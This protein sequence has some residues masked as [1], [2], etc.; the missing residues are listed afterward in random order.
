[1]KLGQRLRS[2][3]KEKRLTLKDLSQLADLSVPYLSDMERGVVNPS[4]ET[5]HKVAKAFN[6][7]VKDLFIGVEEL[8]ELP[9]TGYPEEFNSFLREYGSDYKINDDWKELLLKINFRGRQPTSETEWLELY[10]YLKR[11]LLPKEKKVNNPEK[12]IFKLVQNTIKEYSSTEDA[13]FE[14]I[15]SGLGLNVKEAP[16]SLE[17]DGIHKGNTIIINARIQNQERKRFTQFHEVT[18]YLLEKDGYLISELHDATFSQEGEY[19]I[20]L[21]KFCNIGAAEFL[22]PREKFIRLCEKKGFNVHLI[23]FAASFFKCSTIAATIQ[24]AQVA[25]NQCIAAICEFIQ[26]KTTPLQSQ[27]FNQKEKYLNR[28][29][30][31]VYSAPSPTVKYK[32]AKNTVIP[33]DHLIHDAFLQDHPVEGE[34]YV[35]FRSGKKMPCHCEAL[36]D[37]KRVYVLLHLSTPP[38]ADQKQMKLFSLPNL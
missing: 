8:G 32:L 28:K 12:H 5:L 27:I 1:M 6:M 19:E 24:L 30:H 7:T 9:N 10:L 23:P 15:C 17:I 33:D 20:Q 35:P 26:D 34:S 37:G 25:P 18:H 31:V 36:A 3:R 21:E 13:N 4:V 14:E 29:L 2:L 11:V 22:M 38:S 16:L